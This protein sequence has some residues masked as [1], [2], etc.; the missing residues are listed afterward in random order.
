MD[1]VAAARCKL[2]VQLGQAISVKVA[3]G[4]LI[5]STG[6]C[7]AVPLSIQG[8]PFTVDFLTLPLGGCDVVLGIQWLFTLSPI[9]WDFVNMSMQ[10]QYNGQE[11]SLKGLTAPQ[12]NLIDDEESFET[13]G[14]GSKG[15]FLQILACSSIEPPSL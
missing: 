13:F 4:Q 1:T 9:L 10:F 7:V 12:S 14:C 2:H 3:N 5:E 15:I 6:K 11:I 8:I